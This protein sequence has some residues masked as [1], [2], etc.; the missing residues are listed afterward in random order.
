MEDHRLRAVDH[1]HRIRRR[2]P[3]AAERYLSSQVSSGSQFTF[4]LLDPVTQSP[5]TPRGMVQAVVCERQGRVGQ[6]AQGA[7]NEQQLLLKK[8]ARIRSMGAHHDCLV[9]PDFRA[10]KSDRPLDTGPCWMEELE[11]IF[12]AIDESKATVR[13]SYA[14]IKAN[15]PE[16]RRVNLAL[17]NL[18]RHVGLTSPRPMAPPPILI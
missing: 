6:I 10:T 18:G 15:S 8:A 9:L 13:G 11:V 3:A 14:A 17:V 5:L 4:A 2:C 12:D 16:N 1:Y 7:S